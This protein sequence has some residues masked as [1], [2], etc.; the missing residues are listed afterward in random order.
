M[1]TIILGGRCEGKT[2]LAIFLAY[3]SYPGVIIFD[4]RS[5]VQGCVVW[6]VQELDEAIKEEKWK[7]GVLVYRPKSPDLEAEF[8]EL[9]RYIFDPPR[10]PKG[11]FSFILDEAAT[12]QSAHSVGTELEQ[13]IR[14]HPLQD[15]LIIQTSHSLQ[16]WHRTSR[17][18]VNEM[19][20]FQ[21]QGRSLIAIGEYWGMDDEQMNQVETLPQH[22][23][24]RFFGR[25]E[26]ELW[27]KPEVWYIPV[28]TQEQEASNAQDRDSRGESSETSSRSRTRGGEGNTG[29]TWAR[30]GRREYLSRSEREVSSIRNSRSP[31]QTARGKVEERKN[32]KELVG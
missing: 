16:D 25:N 8:S 13:V 3:Q 6:S 7:E 14:Q 1:N 19:Y 2:H 10:F 21:S 24:I 23:C 5:M 29:S 17:D 15:I 11:R 18:L 22:H 31:S 28:F 12:Q 9:C 20:V 32:Q 27:N 4:T 30:P 26:A